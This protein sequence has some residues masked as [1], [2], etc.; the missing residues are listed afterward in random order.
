MGA[1][2]GIS[3]FLFA[4]GEDNNINRLPEIRISRDLN[5]H[6]LAPEPIQY[7]D[8]STHSIAG[9]LPVK[10]ILRMK[11]VPDSIAHLMPSGRS[12]GI[13]TIVGESFIAQYRLLYVAD[14]NA[15]QIAQINIL[16]ADT[17]PLDYPGISLTTPEMKTHALAILAK[18]TRSKIQHSKAYGLE[19]ALNHVY[20]VGDEVFLDIAYSN[21]TNL[22]YTPDELR[23][24]IED[25]K[26]TKA[27]NVQSVEVKPEWQLYPLI[28][29][30]KQFHNIYVFKKMTFPDNKVLNIELSEKQISGRTIKLQIKYGDLLKADRL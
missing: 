19:A 30:K 8:I 15:G 25:K 1:M 3:S 14:N 9:D 28:D 7:V 16:A 21:K 5:I 12:M 13:V 26:I 24:K 23:F 2:L 11:I 18:P 27:T 10:N 29:F 22:A 4:Q 20:T 6:V 17:K